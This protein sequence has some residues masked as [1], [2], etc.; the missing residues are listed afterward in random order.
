M[1]VI[2]GLDHS[3]MTAKVSTCCIE[4][5]CNFRGDH[6]SEEE[7]NAA[8]GGDNWRGPGKCVC[9]NTRTNK[10]AEKGPIKAWNGGPDVDIPRRAA[11]DY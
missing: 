9:P 2:R 7:E 6:P 10:G 1:I 4:C 8:K 3:L 5:R 11:L